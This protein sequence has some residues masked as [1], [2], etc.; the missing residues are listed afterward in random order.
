MFAPRLTAVNLRWLVVARA[1]LRQIC[2]CSNNQISSQVSFNLRRLASC[3]NTKQK[4]MKIVGVKIKHGG[5]GWSRCYFESKQHSKRKQQSQTRPRPNGRKK[6]IKLGHTQVNRGRKNVS[7]E[8]PY[9]KKCIIYET[10]KYIESAEFAVAGPRGGW[11]RIPP[12]THT[13]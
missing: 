2:A 9:N 8:K 6:M 11:F 13:V 4:S 10:T 5:L 3:L 7:F 12:L 1:S